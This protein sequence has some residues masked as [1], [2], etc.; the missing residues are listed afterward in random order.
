MSLYRRRQN[1]R[2]TKQEPISSFVVFE[3]DRCPPSTFPH[4]ISR[5]LTHD[6]HA[7]VSV[8]PQSPA[9]MSM[10]PE[11]CLAANKNRLFVCIRRGWNRG[12]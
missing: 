2:E 5:Q 12:V 9:A 11:I 8:F 6:T 3:F 10:Q 1:H 7:N 4:L